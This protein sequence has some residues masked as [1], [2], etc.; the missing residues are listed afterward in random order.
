MEKY[1]LS[2]LDEFISQVEFLETE[3]SDFKQKIMEHILLTKESIKTKFDQIL[4]SAMDKLTQSILNSSKS[5][6]LLEIFENMHDIKNDFDMEMG[7][8]TVK[9]SLVSVLRVITKLIGTNEHGLLMNND[10]VLQKLETC[11]KDFTN[12]VEKQFKKIKLDNDLFPTAFNKE[13]IALN[14]EFGQ[15]FCKSKLK[16]D[17]DRKIELSENELKLMS[18]RRELNFFK[19][20]HSDTQKLIDFL[21]LKQTRNEEISDYLKSVIDIKNGMMFRL[22]TQKPQIK[23]TFLKS[24]V[25]N[26]TDKIN[27]LLIINNEFDN[28]SHQTQFRINY[29]V[30][31]I[32]VSP[33]A[34][35]LIV[36]SNQ[37]NNYFYELINQHEELILSEILLEEDTVFN[38]VHFYLDKGISRVAS[39]GLEGL[40]FYDLA[41]ESEIGKMESVQMMDS[42][43]IC[44][45]FLVGIMETDLLVIDCEK[46]K[47]IN[48]YPLD[49]DVKEDNVYEGK[50]FDLI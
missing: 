44:D 19:G 38:K 20:V 37:H 39:S 8:L 50:S 32:I 34:D 14:N 42:V 11:K 2:R 6:V 30:K 31:N 36:Q 48:R 18:F 47:L 26:N 3:Y 1:S 12:K 25:N 45:K 13:A 28:L 9:N 10:Q 7:S 24:G 41:N 35:F 17:E 22:E 46:M 49:F 27:Q 21:N 33:N 4:T 29:N 5:Q 43:M 40:Y 23:S 15:V 16:R